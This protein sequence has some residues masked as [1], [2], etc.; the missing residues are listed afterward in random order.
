MLR[1][2]HDTDAG[3]IFID[4]WVAAELAAFAQQFAGDPVKG[5]LVYLQYG[6][7]QPEFLQLAAG[8]AEGMIWGLSSAPMRTPPAKP[9]ARPT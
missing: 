5:S 8:S 4:H 7:S 3:V 9:S 2:L 1:A 6:P